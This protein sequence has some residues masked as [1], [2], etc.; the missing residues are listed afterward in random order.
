M[1]VELASGAVCTIE[2]KGIRT[3]GELWL[4][5]FVSR[6]AGAA[7]RKNPRHAWHR[8]VLETPFSRR[9]RE[10][11]RTR[12]G[13]SL[14]ACF[15][16][17][18]RFRAPKRP[19]RERADRMTSQETREQGISNVETEYLEI[20]SKGAWAILYQ[21]KIAPL[22]LFFRFCVFPS[23]FHEKR[24]RFLP[25]NVSALLLTRNLNRIAE[26]FSADMIADCEFM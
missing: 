20:N 11:D 10:Q 18:C 1:V 19:N 22:P 23:G 8:S 21:V 14:F 2:S 12:P 3:C 7:L 15:L 16:S 4:R 17:F 9:Q 6:A 24:R 13:H 5:V 26:L 25:A